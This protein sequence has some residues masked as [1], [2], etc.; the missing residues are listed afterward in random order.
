MSS[1]KAV[2]TNFK[3]LERMGKIYAWDTITID[4]W[5]NIAMMDR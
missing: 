1:K 5:E 2:S 3:R 4:E